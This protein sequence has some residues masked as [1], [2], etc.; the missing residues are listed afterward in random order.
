MAMWMLP[1]RVV[2]MADGIAL[3]GVPRTS[4]AEALIRAEGAAKRR[5]ILG[6]RRKAISA[7]CRIAVTACES[8][9]VAPYVPFAVAALDTL[10]AGHPKAA[11]ALVCSLLYALVITYFGKDR[12]RFS[13]KQ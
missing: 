12:Y 9:A 4:I 6:R 13:P 3:Y 5:E 8:E 10:D 2:V 7:D 1:W 11:Q